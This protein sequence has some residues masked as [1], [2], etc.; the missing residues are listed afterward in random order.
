MKN[1]VFIFLLLLTTS[2]LIYA[3]TP[4]GTVAFD[5]PDIPRATFQFHFTRELIA[6]ASTDVPFNTVENLY[7][8]TYDYEADI[9]DKLVGYYGENLKA[10]NWHNLREDSSLLLYILQGTAQSPRVDN[11][12]SGIFALVK[13]DAEVYLLNVVGNIPPQQIERLLANLGELGIAIPEL[14]SLGELTFRKPAVPTEPLPTLFRIDGVK[15]ATKGGSGTLKISRKEATKGLNVEFSRNYHENHQGHWTYRGHPIEH[16]QIR[17]NEKKQV[18]KISDGLKGRAQDITE[19]LDSQLLKN[20]TADTPRFVIDTSERKITISAEG[21]RYK[22]EPTMLAKSFRTREGSPIHEIVIRGNQHTKANTVREALEK[23]PEEIEQAIEALPHAILTLKKAELLIEE[24]DSQRTAIIIMT[25]KPP[26]LRSYVDGTPQLGFN[27]VTGWELGARIESGFRRQSAHRSSFRIGSL[28]ESIGGTNSKLFG[29]I[30]YGFGNKQAYYRGGGS[31]VWGESHSWHLGLTAQFHRATSIIAPDLFAGYD[32]RGT[33][34]LR[35]LGVPDH[36]NYYLRE[37]AEIALQWKLVPP[38]HSFK[39]VLLA[40]SH[41]SLQKSTDWYF[42]NWQSQAEVR[43]N[44]LITPGRLRSATFK[45]D[46]N[47]RNNY[48]GWHNTFFVEHSSPAF[49]SDFEWTRFQ[50]HLR[51]AYPLGDN[52]IRVRAV[53]GSATASLPVQRQFV[54]GGIGTLNGYPLYAFAGDT[55]FL[56]NLEFLYNVFN[57]GSR[58]LSIAFLLDEGQVWNLSE[59]QRRFDPK[60]SAG[61]GLQFATEVDIFRFNVAK[62]FD[63]EQG[64][65]FNLMFF[66]SF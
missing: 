18:A 19:L 25:E 61:I 28:P 59:N 13:S 39:L 27:R 53:V 16:I 62:A 65:Q 45:Y 4:D 7:I 29:Q 17:A 52:Q 9:F 15:Q 47:T 49:G 8:R 24:E 20:R 51:Y 58:N 57:F 26:P 35:I 31:A 54:M 34:L 64:I 42:F 30:A 22:R 3:Q 14:E 37:G 10:K 11:T 23:G 33:V 32:D 50:T 6:L 38:T 5:C 56:F 43:E 46:F 41:E 36:Q 55:G 48:L 2:T 44:P 60:G 21:L 66:Y 12:V 40:E 63:S 1:S